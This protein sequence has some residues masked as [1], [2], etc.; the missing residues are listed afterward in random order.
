[1]IRVLLPLTLAAGIPLAP[2]PPQPPAPRD[3]DR[4]E[5]PTT[6][7]GVI[8]GRVT[9]RE[10]GQPISRAIVVAFSDTAL[11][12][13]VTRLEAHTS[14]D[15]RYELKGLRAG[16]RVVLYPTDKVQDGARAEVR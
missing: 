12:E 3:P 1:M 15:G 5:R 9:D 14:S 10:T 4:A 13:T 6:G 7:T 8:R 2:P 16:E 11:A